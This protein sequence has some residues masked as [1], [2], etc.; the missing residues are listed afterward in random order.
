MS[1]TSDSTAKAG[2]KRKLSLIIQKTRGFLTAFY[3]YCHWLFPLIGSIIVVSHTYILLGGGENSS[4]DNMYHVLNEYV[5]LRGILAGDNP[6]GPVGLEFGMPILRFYQ[7]LFYLWNVAV[8]LVT[9]I[10]VMVWHNVTL[11]VCYALSPFA[12]LHFLMKVGLNRF[13][14]GLGA[15]ASLV[16]IAAFGNSLEAFH[17]AGIVTQSM[18]GLFFPWF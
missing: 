15:F 8:T 4:G 14:A 1:L 16:S 9:G 3:P 17:Q 10:D 7:A 11:V 6:L 18:G 13:A 12:Y 5:I 2:N